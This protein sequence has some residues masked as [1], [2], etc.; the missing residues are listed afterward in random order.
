MTLEQEL[1]VAETEACSRP[2]RRCPGYPTE[3]HGQH[4]AVDAHCACPAMRVDGRSAVDKR[5][6]WRLGSYAPDGASGGVTAVVTAR[7]PLP[8]DDRAVPLSW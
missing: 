2:G 1:K 5:H 8:S 7:S 4:A 3:L 6:D